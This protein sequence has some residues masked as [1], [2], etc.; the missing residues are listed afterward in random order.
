MSE[1]KAPVKPRLQTGVM[2]AMT[3]FDLFVLDITT[4]EDT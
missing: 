4:V 1:M 2:L 3:D